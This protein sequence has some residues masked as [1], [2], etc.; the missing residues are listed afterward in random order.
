MTVL[1]KEKDCKRSVRILHR[2]FVG[3]KIQRMDIIGS[4]SFWS[5]QEGQLART[6]VSRGRYFLNNDE[7]YKPIYKKKKEERDPFFARGA[8]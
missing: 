2:T 3:K 7:N 5:Q 6:E 8:Y 4:D 1:V